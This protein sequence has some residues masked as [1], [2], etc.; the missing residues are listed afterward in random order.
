[1]PMPMP[2][3]FRKWVPGFAA[4][5]LLTNPAAA[6]SIRFEPNRG[7]GK[8]DSTRHETG[9]YLTLTQNAFHRG[10]YVFSGWNTEADG[11]GIDYS[12]ERSFFMPDSDLTLYAQWREAGE[13]LDSKCG[14]IV[15]EFVRAVPP[16]SGACYV[17]DYVMMVRATHPDGVKS[18]RVMKPVSKIGTAEPPFTG[19]DEDLGIFWTRRRFKSGGQ[20][21]YSIIIET[22][23][24][25]EISS[26]GLY[27]DDGWRQIEYSKRI[28][29]YIRF[30][31]LRDGD[32]VKANQ[33]FVIGVDAMDP[34]GSIHHLR[35]G[36]RYPVDDLNGVLSLSLKVN[37]QVVETRKNAPEEI[38]A[39][40]TA[41]VNSGFYKFH[42]V[43]LPRGSHRLSIESV[44]RRGNR[45]ESEV[46]TVRAD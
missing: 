29:E 14:E 30:I 34:D 38:P 17:E 19:F 1:M 39:N 23:K 16:R 27:G 13:A 31:N 10:G 15:L 22:E 9:D 43:K 26:S 45:M 18:V 6:G 44:D 46:I 33:P 41:A 7:S 28:P 40:E 12:D 24:G 42:G 35:T 11:S 2:I 32:P 37:G 21:Q 20:L 25:E 3:V 4:I 8:M 36:H 5:V